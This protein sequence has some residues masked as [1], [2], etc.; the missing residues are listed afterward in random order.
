CNLKNK[1]DLNFQ[2]GIEA[3]KIIFCTTSPK[4][5]KAYPKATIKICMGSM[6]Q[7]TNSSCPY[8]P[9][10]NESTVANTAM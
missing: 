3:Y 1:I 7:A 9:N 5:K 8:I 6:N 4:T 2:Y 10:S